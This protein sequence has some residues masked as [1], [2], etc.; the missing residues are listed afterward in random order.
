MVKERIVYFDVLNVVSCFSVVCLHCNGYVHTYV[1]DEWWWLRV[2]IEVLFYFAVPVFFMLSGATLFNYHER[3]SISTFYKK[4]I[5]RTV[6]PFIFW[7]VVFYLLYLLIK[8]IGNIYWK[9]II[10]NF[11]SGHIP[12]TNYWFFI[13]LFALYL[14]IPFLSHVVLN[15][16]C[17]LLLFLILLLFLLQSFIPTIYEIL[18]IHLD[19]SIPI[20]GAYLV[21]ALIGYYLSK[22]N[23]EME[24]VIYYSVV[25]LAL[26]SLVLRYILIYISEE[27]STFLFTYMGLYVY[28]PSIFV[29]MTAKR[30]FFNSRYA[31]MWKFLSS[32]SLGI[33]LLHTFIIAL[34]AKI[35]NYFNPIFLVFAPFIVYFFSI[36]VVSL[37]QRNK[38]CRYLIP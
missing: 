36:A 17:R 21:Y 5:K 30:F 12:F 38:Y 24:N 4:R 26:L 29:F 25:I 37:L 22:N 7:G 19:Y 10:E 23:V 6:L 14:F 11:S 8:G 13:P 18:N 20:G 3:Y 28:F 15:V 2:M 33:Y 34:L 27:K 32:K 1:K 35:A 16:S 9:D 31:H